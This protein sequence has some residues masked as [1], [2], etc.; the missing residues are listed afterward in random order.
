MWQNSSIITR[1]ALKAWTDANFPSLCTQCIQS[2]LLSIGPSTSVS[3]FLQIFLFQN[4]WLGNTFQPP[5]KSQ[6]SWIT[7]KVWKVWSLRPLYLSI[8]KKFSQFEPRLLTK[9]KLKWVQQ[10]C[11]LNPQLS[12]FLLNYQFKLKSKASIRSLSSKTK[13][14]WPHTKPHRVAS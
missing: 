6:L 12:W 11:T 4:P 5:T 7:M 14:F 8:N 2:S 3:I 9:R 1:T 13:Q 10:Q